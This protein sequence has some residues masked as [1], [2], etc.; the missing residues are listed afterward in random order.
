MTKWQSQA[1]GVG[2][3]NAMDV[4]EWTCLLGPNPVSER[5]IESV[6][7]EREKDGPS[8]IR[9]SQYPLVGWWHS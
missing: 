8:V 1:E 5:R 4:L 6:R 9:V 2:L 7:R 3:L